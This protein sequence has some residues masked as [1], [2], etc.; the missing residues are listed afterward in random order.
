MA[1]ELPS[2]GPLAFRPGSDGPGCRVTSRT[3][4]GRATEAGIGR[5]LLSSRGQAV[6]ASPRARA[7]GMVTKPRARGMGV[8]VPSSSRSDPRDAVAIQQGIDFRLPPLDERL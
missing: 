3:G 8:L 5:R 1:Y 2:Y 4:S 7:Q 6:S